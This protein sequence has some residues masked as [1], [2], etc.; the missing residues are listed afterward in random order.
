LLLN[1]DERAKL[2]LGGRVASERYGIEVMVTRF[3]DGICQALVRDG[4]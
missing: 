4:R 3:A 2:G 1:E